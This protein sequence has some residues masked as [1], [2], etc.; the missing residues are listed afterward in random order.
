V[1]W[2]LLGGWAGAIRVSAPRRVRLEG[3]RCRRR[4]LR[5]QDLAVHRFIPV[6]T[7]ICTLIDLAAHHSTDALEAMIGEADIRR[8]CTP[9]DV[10]RA[11][12]DVPPRPGVAILRRLLDRRTFRL[13]RSKLERLFI[14]I[15]LG[16]GLSR[17]LTR[18][19]VGG[20]EVDFFW[21]DLGLVVETDGLTYHR[22]PQQQTAD[23]E[24]GQLHF[25]NGLTPLRF[26][27]WQV[28]NEPDYVERLLR[29]ARERL[30][31]AAA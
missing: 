3:I 14:P 30:T 28:T 2:G 23:V 5:P 13:T 4:T 9:D 22:T 29:R 27:H 31:P 16:A 26:T 25:A 20:V 21:P 11:L 24:R 18:A 7:P 8:L 15:A 6:T 12:D 19:Q 17:P 10:R 1:L